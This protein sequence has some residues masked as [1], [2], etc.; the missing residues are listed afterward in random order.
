M[1]QVKLLVQRRKGEAAAA[2]LPKG[3][4]TVKRLETGTG[5]PWRFSTA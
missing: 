1:F 2:G 3:S 4:L 5:G